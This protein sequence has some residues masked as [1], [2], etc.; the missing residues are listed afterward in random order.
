MSRIEHYKDPNAPKANSLVPAAS[1][2]ILDDDGRVL[3][4]RRADNGLWSLPGGVMEIGESIGECIVREVR[5][6]TGLDIEPTAV[7]GVYSNPNHVI[8]YANGE[9]RQQFS[10]CFRCRVVSGDLAPSEEST[11][12]RWI[13]AANLGDVDLQPSIEIRIRDALENPSAARWD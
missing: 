6:E 1:A 11:A 4:H 12:L 10:V 5:E 13:H 3:L 7:I 2:V 8:E 9:V